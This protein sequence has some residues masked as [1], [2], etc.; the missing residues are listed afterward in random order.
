[1][2]AEAGAG[3]TALVA[4]IYAGLPLLGGG[5]AW[6]VKHLLTVRRV[7]GAVNDQVTN[8][9]GTNLREDLDFI[10]DLVLDVKADTAWVR[11]DHIDLVKRV[12]KLEDVA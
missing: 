9:H 4:L 2:I 3:D 8:S 11:R 7:L 10:R 6:F 1:M 12:E 5:V